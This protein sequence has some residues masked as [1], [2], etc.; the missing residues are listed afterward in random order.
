MRDRHDPDV[1]CAVKALVQRK[2]VLHSK[3]ETNPGELSPSLDKFGVRMCRKLA[4]AAGLVSLLASC[5]RPTS[6]HSAR[7]PIH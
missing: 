5:P 2:L 7:C 6:K 1:S 4:G 3:S